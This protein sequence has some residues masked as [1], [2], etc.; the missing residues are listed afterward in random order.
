MLKT[1][2]K[3][4]LVLF[5]I[6]IFIS[7]CCYATSDVAITTE[8]DT[9]TTPEESTHTHEEP[10]W[11]NSDLFVCEDTVNISNV[12]DG[13]AF[14]IG[15]DVTISGEIGGDLFVLADKLNIEGGYIYSS[16]FACA[17]E[18]TINGV[19]Y[20]VY[21]IC[22][23]FNIESNGFIY[24]DLKITS[25]NL[26]IN[27]MIRRNAFISAENINFVESTQPLIGGNLNYS[28]KSEI[29]I[30]ENVVTGEVNYTPANIKTN[31]NNNV[32]GTISSYV[33]D[34]IRTLIS[35][36]VIT[37]FLLWL[38][39]KFVER[40]GNIK[41]SKS[42]IS[43]GIGFAT[44]IAFVL[45]SILLI[46]SVLG[47]SIFS[48]LLLV[49]TLLVYI[50]FSITSIFFG[51]LFT[52]LLKVEGKVKFVLFTLVSSIIL[53]VISQIPF[54]GGFFAIITC[55]FGIGLTLVNIFVKNEK[56]KEVETAEVEVKE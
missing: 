41:V 54:V 51:K 49:F 44:P 21:A 32:V 37:L 45:A 35:T 18:I 10:S 15:K 25:A 26:N 5:L 3:V 46:I 6:M 16:I 50:G 30:P 23:T 31:N 38:T 43:L 13:N 12:V 28:S 27:G 56:V 55:L 1:K 8:T 36:F 40:V 11:T 53:W 20:D 29:A 39:P 34:L 2:S 4:L 9:T 19:V 48:H 17:N 42:F 14:I 52:K 47:L 33:F 22:N 7:S 24:R